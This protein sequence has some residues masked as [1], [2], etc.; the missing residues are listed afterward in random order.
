[1][2]MLTYKMKNKIA[3]RES[4]VHGFWLMEYVAGNSL[5]KEYLPN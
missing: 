4:T 5:F 3:K 1:M 2:A